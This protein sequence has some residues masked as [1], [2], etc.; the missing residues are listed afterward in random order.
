MFCLN[1]L[2]LRFE[3]REKKANF[4]D[5]NVSASLIITS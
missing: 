2:L 5:K 3:L 1:E 4:I